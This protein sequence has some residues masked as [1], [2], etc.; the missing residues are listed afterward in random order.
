MDDKGIIVELLLLCVS[1]LLGVEFYFGL[2]LMMVPN[3]LLK[4]GNWKFK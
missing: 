4:A 1:E 2:T 3:K